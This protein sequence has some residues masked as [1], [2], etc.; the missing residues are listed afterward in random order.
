MQERDL[1]AEEASMRLLVD[2]LDSLLGETL[3]LPAEV[4]DLVGDVMHSRPALREEP[5]DV[6]ILTERAEELD[7]ALADADGGG[8]DAL[9]GDRFALLELAS[10]DAPVRLERLVQVVDGDPEVVNPVRLHR[11]EDASGGTPGCAAS[12]PVGLLSVATGLARLAVTAL[13][14]DDPADRLARP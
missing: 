1:E 5:A 7:A 4:A 11:A 9:L 2:Q 13:E 14:R 8:L 6:S 3:E 10:E 12:G